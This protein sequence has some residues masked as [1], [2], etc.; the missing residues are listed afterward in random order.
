M[1]VEMNSNFAPVQSNFTLPDGG[2]LMITPPVGKTYWMLRVQLTEK[3]SIIAFPKFGTIGIGFAIETNW[4]TNL[5]YTKPAKDIF[6][7]I[8]ENKGDDNITDEDCIKAIEMLQSV[9][10]QILI[11]E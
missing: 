10:G 2:L 9:L 11:G 7:H 8:Q 6:N 3:Q 4:N 5:P 1:Q